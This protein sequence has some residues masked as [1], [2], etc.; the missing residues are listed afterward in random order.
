MTKR[1]ASSKPK[2]AITDKRSPEEYFNEA[3]EGLLAIVNSYYK[4][5]S[6]PD[7]VIEECVFLNNFNNDL[8]I[9]LA[10]GMIEER[11]DVY[12]KVIDKITDLTFDNIISDEWEDPFSEMLEY[13]DSVEDINELMLKYARFDA[14]RPFGEKVEKLRITLLEM[15]N[16]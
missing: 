15:D 8:N 4:N 3:K 7:K 1:T 16:K 14:V 9:P 11:K 2:K 5:A 10:L 13:I 6:R 12:L